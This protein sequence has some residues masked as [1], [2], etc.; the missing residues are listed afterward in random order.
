MADNVFGVLGE[1]MIVSYY[2]GIMLL[3]GGA[4]LVSC[5]VWRGALF[6]LR[7]ILGIIFLVGAGALYFGFAGTLS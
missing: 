2:T 5:L 7:L 4:L 1:M 6:R 3:I